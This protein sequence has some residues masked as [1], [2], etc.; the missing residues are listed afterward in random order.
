MIE[1]PTYNDIIEEI[2]SFKWK[3][4][5]TNQDDSA[6]FDAQTI[7]LDLSKYQ[8][9][10]IRFKITNNSSSSTSMYYDATIEGITVRAVMFGV[11]TSSSAVSCYMR[12]F[13]PTNTGITFSKGWNKQ[14]SST[15]AASA[16]TTAMIPSQ[17]WAR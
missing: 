4:V 15:S 9:V 10:R 3:S 13:T 16:N 11:L 8:E 7:P 5:W 14:V 2:K 17:I 12:E 1:N 6:N